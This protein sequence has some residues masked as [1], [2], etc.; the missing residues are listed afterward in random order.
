MLF[1]LQRYAGE[2]ALSSVS[3]DIFGIFSLAKPIRP[4]REG[5]CSGGREGYSGIRFSV[6]F[7]EGDCTSQ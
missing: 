7:F 1:I 5:D 2:N 3:A 4:H 6:L